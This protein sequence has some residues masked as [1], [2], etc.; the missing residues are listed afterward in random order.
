MIHDRC[1]ALAA[2][3][4]A[5]VLASAVAGAQSAPAGGQAGWTPTKTPWGH[6]DFQGVWKA[7][8]TTKPPAAPAPPPPPSGGQNRGGG[9]G[10]GPEHWYEAEPLV[11]LRQ[12]KILEGGVPP[13]TPEGKKRASNRPGVMPQRPTGPE[14]FSPWDR[15]ITRGVPGSMIPINYNNNYQFLQTPDYVVILYEMIHDVRAIPLNAKSQPPEGMRFWMGHPRGR[16]DGDTLVVETTR[17]TDKT[18]IIYGDGHHSE[19]LRLTERF[20]PVDAQTMRYE[21]TVDDRGTWEKPFTAVLMLTRGG[22]DDRIYEY[23]CHEG[24]YGLA[25]ML[26]GARAEDRADAAKKPDAG[27]R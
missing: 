3:A 22:A 6:P 19:R 11:F 4:A 15:C 9:T 14:D 21:F 17:F 13:L 24:N 12:L 16:W 5:V 25:N 20:T 23:A 26:T 1:S 2:A 7:I 18:R 27:Q 8:E 10:A